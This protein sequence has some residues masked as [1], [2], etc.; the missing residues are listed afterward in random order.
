MTK[1]NL[2]LHLQHNYDKININMW[3][4]YAYIFACTYWLHINP[5]WWY[6]R[7]YG[8]YLQKHK[9]FKKNLTWTRHS[10]IMNVWGQNSISINKNLFTMWQE[11]KDQLLQDY[12]SHLWVLHMYTN[13][14]LVWQDW[15]LQEGAQYMHTCKGSIVWDWLSKG[16]AWRSMLHK[17][18]HLPKC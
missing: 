10:M 9:W 8:Y 15:S 4:V 16:G 3:N 13:N 17:K 18:K 14:S 12:S 7:A 11:L 1:S 2:M 5:T 6:K